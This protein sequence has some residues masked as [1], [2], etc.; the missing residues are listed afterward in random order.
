MKKFSKI[1]AALMAVMC[2]AVSVIPMSASA[3]SAR[4][5]T[6]RNTGNF[7]TATAD[8][9]LTATKYSLTNDFVEKKG[10][11]VKLTTAESTNLFGI[12]YSGVLIGG[13]YRYGRTSLF[14]KA[15]STTTA[16]L[17]KTTRSTSLRAQPSTS[18][19]SIQTL[20]AGTVLEVVGS[21]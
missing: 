17:Y 18:A 7:Y 1:I 4:T 9:N 2:I 3:A 14:K 15:G 11:L 21:I 12:K 6:V 8:A 20:N 13:D 16:T 19:K 5:T 10:S